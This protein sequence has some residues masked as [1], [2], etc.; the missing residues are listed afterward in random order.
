MIQLTVSNMA[1]A[2]CATTIANAVKAIDPTATIEANPKT[3]LVK[4]ET[5]QSETAVKN[6]IAASG[7]TVT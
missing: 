5:Q 4:V 6:A 7:Y 3:K 2:A 1:C